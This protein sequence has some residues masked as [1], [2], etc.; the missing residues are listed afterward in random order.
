MLAR[1]LLIEE[2]FLVRDIVCD[3]IIEDRYPLIYLGMTI[4]N[5]I[6]ITG[7][8]ALV[9]GVIGDIDFSPGDSWI[10]SR[11]SGIPPTAPVPAPG[12]NPR[13]WNR[14]RSSCYW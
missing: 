13:S 9:G 2:G 5:D 8:T 14:C 6:D 10:R 1:I 3:R 11:N 7:L 12:G 4:L